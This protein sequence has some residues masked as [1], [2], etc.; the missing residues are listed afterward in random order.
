[1]D[2]FTGIIAISNSLSVYPNPVKDILTIDYN[3]SD[4]SIEIYSTDGRI[5][6]KNEHLNSNTVAVSGL[7]PALY[8]IRIAH[9]GQ[10]IGRCH[11]VKE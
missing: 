9:D 5:V 2:E 11:F 3:A 10:E 4:L 6:S 8:I 7:A 1:L